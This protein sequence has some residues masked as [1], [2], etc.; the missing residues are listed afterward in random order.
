[1]PERLGVMAIDKHGPAS[2]VVTAIDISPAIA[3]EKALGKID[4]E[5]FRGAQDHPWLRIAASARIGP[6]GAGVPADFHSVN[7]W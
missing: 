6:G 3:N 5:R 7:R 2:G 1:M 4:L